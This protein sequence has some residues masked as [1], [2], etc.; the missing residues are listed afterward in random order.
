MSALIGHLLLPPTVLLWVSALGF[1][2]MAAGRPSGKWLA[3]LSWLALWVL[4]TPLVSGTLLDALMPPYK[5]L[6]GSEA[7]AIVILAGGIVRGP[8]EYGPTAGRPKDVTLERLRYGAWLARRL[9]KPVLVTGGDPRNTG[10]PES[11]IMA[12]V[13][14]EDYGI[15]PRWVESHSRTTAENARNSARMLKASGITRIYLVTHAWHLYRAQP[16]F[17]R[18]GLLVIPAGTGYHRRPF[19]LYSL[20]PSAAALHDSYYALHEGL[21]RLWY[22]WRPTPS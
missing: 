7:D 20:L 8:T 22:R 14:K 11:S 18:Q 10:Q 5:P 2:L 9:H 16:E 15:T 1:L 12:D 3:G 4:S 17:E 6:T 13:L 21:G 19:D